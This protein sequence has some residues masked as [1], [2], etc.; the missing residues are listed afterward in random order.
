MGI[1]GIVERLAWNK[2]FKI[3]MKTLEKNEIG[4]SINHCSKMLR[5]EHSAVEAYQS[6]IEKFGDVPGMHEIR[7]IL[8]DHRIVIGELEETIYSMGGMPDNESGAW[9]T[10]VGLVQSSANL[11][12]EGSA[13]A[14]LKAGEEKGLFDYIAAVDAGFLL[15]TC[16]NL[17]RYRLIPITQ[18]HIRTLEVIG[19]VMS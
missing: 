14:A 11:F 4:E 19:G 15:L 18:H 17:Y 7:R 10:F 1:S 8:D 9:G 3:G 16:E 12:G 6:V 13:L 5:G 2:R